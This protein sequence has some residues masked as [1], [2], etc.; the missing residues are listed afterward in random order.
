[1]SFDILSFTNAY[2]ILY[3]H[4]TCIYQ[5]NYITQ[6][7]MSDSWHIQCSNLTEE[8]WYVII[9]VMCPRGYLHNNFGLIYALGHIMYGYIL[10]LPKKKQPELQKKPLL[11]QLGGHIAFMI[12]YVYIFLTVLL[13]DFS[14]LVI[15]VHLWPLILRSLL[16]LLS[17]LWFVGTSNV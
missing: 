1:M 7:S 13:L 9:K 14:T 2:G 11:W 16:G 10:L 4:K 6:V 8:K 17:T 3:I 12:T 5:A 15:V